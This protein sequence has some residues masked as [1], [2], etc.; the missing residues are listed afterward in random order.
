M[1]AKIEE[2]EAKVEKMVAN[3]D[4]LVAEMTTLDAKPARERGRE[5]TPQASSST[6]NSSFA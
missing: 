1:E 3:Y 2:V 4:E 6:R 5:R